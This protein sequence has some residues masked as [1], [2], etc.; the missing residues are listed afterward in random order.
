MV[1]AWVWDAGWMCLMGGRKC[2]AGLRITIYGL[3]T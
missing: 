3:G 2:V 1:R